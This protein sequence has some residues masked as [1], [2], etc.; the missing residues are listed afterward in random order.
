MLR[1]E[2]G[3]GANLVKCEISKETDAHKC[4]SLEFLNFW[5]I[6][7]KAKMLKKQA[8]KWNKLQPILQKI[9]KI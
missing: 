5:S 3:E 4:Q 8:V 7:I 6:D 1:S 9:N 2:L